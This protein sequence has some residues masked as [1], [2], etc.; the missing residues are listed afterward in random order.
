MLYQERLK[1]W[2]IIRLLPDRKI[3]V[4]RFRS[5]SDAEGHLKLLRQKMPD[6]KLTIVF[7]RPP[8]E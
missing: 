5:L 7:E 2:A 4:D 8:E 6:D 3:V 1:T